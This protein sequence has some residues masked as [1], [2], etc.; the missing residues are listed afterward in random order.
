MLAPLGPTQTDG[1]AATYAA[2]QLDCARF[3][4]T[5]RA[6][7][8]TLIGGRSRDASTGRSA[9]WVFRAVPARGGVRLEGWLD[10][11][12][13]W[14]S[15]AGTRVDPDTDGLLGGRYRGILTGDGRY[16]PV[17]RPFVPDEVAEVMQMGAA[18]DDLL[19]RLPSRP[20]LPGQAWSDSA[21]LEIRRLADS[22]A[23][24]VSMLRFRLSGRREATE[25]T[26]S[27]DSLPFEV[28]QVIAEETEITWHPLRGLVRQDRQ[29]SV[30]TMVPA[31]R[32][33]KR[34][35]RSGVEQRITLTR[36]PTD[37]AS[38]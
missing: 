28:R 17:A 18:L 22:A 12:A 14:R 24:G 9:V 25:E 3:R 21:G 34:P 2:H 23:G 27:E 35:I 1:A 32:R 13:V 7:I 20:L 37:R 29:L 30:E 4:E 16:S 33:L 8:R 31:S 10:S 19:P 15:A 36:L 5:T 11:L 38:C 6:Q 26:V